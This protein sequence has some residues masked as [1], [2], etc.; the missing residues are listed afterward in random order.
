[1]D[2]LKSTKGTRFES[3]SFS[4]DKNQ[5][6]LVGFGLLKTNT[7]L[8]LEKETGIRGKVFLQGRH[9][10]LSKRAAFIGCLLGRE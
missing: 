8:R 5:R 7:G 3:G 10:L 2:Q 4:H 9:A 1:M 6:S